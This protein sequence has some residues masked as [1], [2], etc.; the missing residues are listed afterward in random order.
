[1]RRIVPRQ[2]SPE[3]Q[4]KIQRAVNAVRNQSQR[5]IKCPYCR[6]NGII[7][8]DDTRGHVQTKCKLCG[9]E[10]IVDVVNMRRQRSYRKSTTININIK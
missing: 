1:M 7:V 8:F 6:H 10:T 4:I 3:M 5:A 9:R 2:P